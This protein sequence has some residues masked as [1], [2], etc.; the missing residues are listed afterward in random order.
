MV[1]IMFFACPCVPAISSSPSPMASEDVGIVSTKHKE[2]SMEWLDVALVDQEPMASIVVTSEQDA[3]SDES[4]APENSG[5]SGNASDNGGRVKIGVEAAL[6]GMSFDFGW[7]KVMRSCVLGLE[8][9]SRF[10]PQGFARP[11]GIE[12]VPVPKGDEAVVFEDFFVAGLHKPPHRVLLDILHKFWVQLHKLTPNAIVQ[13]SK[14]IWAV[15]SCGGR[16]NN[17]VFAHHYELHYQNKKIHLE[18][19]ETTFTAQFGCISFQPS[20]FGNHARLT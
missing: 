12:S 13:I 7:S 9:S 16:P 19:S 14:F 15:M 18:G 10:F 6:A 11:P 3:R 2:S 1:C 5:D 20:R 8:S 17:E 4:D